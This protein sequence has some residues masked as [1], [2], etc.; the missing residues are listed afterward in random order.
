MDF[1]RFCELHCGKQIHWCGL[2]LHRSHQCHWGGGDAGEFVSHSV[3]CICILI[4]FLL[5]F[6]SKPSMPLKWRRCRWI[7][8][9]LCIL[10]LYFN[11]VC[12]CICIEAI[13][14]TEVE[15]MQVNVVS[16]SAF[17]FLFWFSFVFVLSFASKPSM[18][19]KWRRCMWKSSLNLHICV[20]TCVLVLTWWKYCTQWNNDPSE[21][22]KPGKK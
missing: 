7:Y 16:H 14:A 2:Y 15:E 10:Y 13:N 21:N 4:L 20:R 9:P 12:T 11:P 3:F 18:P 6:A 17:V 5:V 19:P 22:S 8:F 1:N